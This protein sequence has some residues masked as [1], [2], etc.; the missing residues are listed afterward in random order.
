MINEYRDKIAVI[1]GAANGLGSVLATGVAARKCHLALVDV[2][3]AGLVKLQKK[4]A[5][6]ELR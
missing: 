2:D 1:T 4:L 5:R 3:E 6:A